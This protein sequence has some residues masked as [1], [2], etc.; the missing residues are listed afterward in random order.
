MGRSRSSSRSRSRSRE[1]YRRKRSRSRD[2]DNERSRRFV[3]CILPAHTC[4]DNGNSP[5]SSLLLLFLT[6]FSNSSSLHLR[7]GRSRS[8][9]GDR[10]GSR[11][12]HRGADQHRPSPPPPTAAPLPFSSHQHQHQHQPNAMAAGT[13]ANTATPFVAGIDAAALMLDRKQREV[14][15]G[16]LAVGII[17]KQLLEEF[18]NQALSHMMADPITT[19]PV[20]NVNFD[21]QGRFA[22]VEFR[23]RELANQALLMDKMIDIHGKHLSIGRPKGYQEPTGPP[24]PLAI[25]APQAPQVNANA[26]ATTA[27]IAN[28]SATKQNGTT[29]A[30]TTTTNTADAAA[31]GGGVGATPSPFILLSNILPA[32]HLRTEE[33]RHH[34]I[35]DIKE[36][37]S[38][39]GEVE[40][41]IVPSPPPTLQDQGPGRAYL[42]YK[43]IEDAKKGIKIF[44]T[45]TL[46]ENRIK[47]FF[48]GADEV[49]A[50]K[51]GA[52]AERHF[53]VANIPLPGLYTIVPLPAG[54]SGLSA[55]NPQL[56]SVVQT[57]PTIA[58]AMT[59]G[60]DEDQVPFEEGWV[61]LRGFPPVV[62]KDHI[63]EFFKGCGEVSRDDVKVVHSADG[64]SLG[65]AFVRLSGPRAKLRLALARDR[66]PLPPIKVP[67]EVLT[68]FEE[69]M[70]RRMMSGCVL[71]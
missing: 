36:E 61:K 41:V 45:R 20:V 39:Y 55:L 14:Y 12:D 62:T 19:P 29:A 56:A 28:A 26:S 42:L 33:Q 17:T 60:I 11:H 21:I 54:I 9:D 65:E 15:V 25:A 35:E 43:G 3:V 5:S 68:S 7:S 6:L 57:N 63:V 10:R 50:A 27:A 40:E 70:E 58:A 32:G 2:K 52:W 51:E 49:E 47:A 1:R 13:G 71:V 67:A 44:H 16:N 4:N 24:L 53:S 34:L 18:F 22:F 69:D 48:V 66:S 8:R 46:D 30:S 38:K 37:A 59:S 23:T 64:T 31:G